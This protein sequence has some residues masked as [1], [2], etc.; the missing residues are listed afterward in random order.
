M[1]FVSFYHQSDG[2]LTLEREGF[3]FVEE[4]T[5]IIMEIQVS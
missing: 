1:A 5:I 3:G 4:K 2:R